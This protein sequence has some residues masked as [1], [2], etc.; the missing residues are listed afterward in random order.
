M[1]RFSLHNRVSFPCG[2]L[3]TNAMK[4]L[5]LIASL[6]IIAFCCHAQQGEIIYRNFD[7]DSILTIHYITNYEDSMLINL[8]GE[9]HPDI[10]MFYYVDSDGAFP[11][12][13]SVYSDSL[14]LCSVEQ[15]DI[16]SEVTNWRSTLDP[17]L[18]VANNY[19]GFRVK[20]GDGYIYGW[21]ETRFGRGCGKTYWTHWDFDRTAYCTIPNYPLLWGQT[22]LTESIK[23]TESTAFATIYPNPTTVIVT[24][25]GESLRQAEVFNMLGQ[26]MLSIKGEGN[27][28][29]IDM[30]ALPAGVYF[31]NVTEESGKKCVRKVVK[32]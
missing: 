21:F 23:E 32:E 20:H 25:T 10:I 30:T 26:Q 6:T 8:D 11:Y 2:D 12:I 15:D 16:I 17:W 22:S 28:L 29:Q 13:K 4:R 31:V 14:Q 18:V 7:P 3:K 1:S 19:Y 9:G 5:V 27:E 24:V